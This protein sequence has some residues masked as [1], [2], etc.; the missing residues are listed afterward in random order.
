MLVR[1]CFH[2]CVPSA[3]G[4][5]MNMRNA[6]WIVS[7]FI[8]EIDY[9]LARNRGFAEGHQTKVGLRESLSSTPCSLDN[10]PD[11][12]VEVIGSRWILT[13]ES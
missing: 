11:G 3:D 4:I 7:L 1:E 9:Q 10:L 2:V 5:R 6:D 13:T 12:F 8:V